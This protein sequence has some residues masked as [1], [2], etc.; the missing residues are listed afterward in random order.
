M[1]GAFVARRVVVVVW[2]YAHSRPEWPPRRQGWLW[3]PA[4]ES[5]PSI[6]VLSLGQLLN[7]PEA[8][9]LLDVR[10]PAEFAQGAITGA[11]LYP[12][13][14]LEVEAPPF[15]RNSLLLVYCHTDRRSTQAISLSQ[16]Y[17]FR[18][19]FQITGGYS[20]YQDAI[21]TAPIQPQ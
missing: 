8:Y 9:H 17:G 1:A 20:A 3:I 13:S 7:G 10:T 11:T 14:Q 15:S 4:Q 18:N 19:L 12:L 5:I 2:F 16:A 6:D 21:A